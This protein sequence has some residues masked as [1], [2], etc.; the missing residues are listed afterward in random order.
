MTLIPDKKISAYL[1]LPHSPHLSQH[2]SHVQGTD[3]VTTQD[4]SDQTLTRILKEIYN[5]HSAR[6]CK[7]LLLH[8]LKFTP[9]LILEKIERD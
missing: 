2:L 6:P 3:K 8:L 1:P 5:R 4:L 9:M 7:L